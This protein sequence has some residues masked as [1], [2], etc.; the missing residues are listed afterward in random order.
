MFNTTWMDESG[1]IHYISGDPFEINWIDIKDEDG[2]LIDLAGWKIKL[3][4]FNSAGRNTILE[5]TE[6]DCDLTIP[7]TLTIRKA[8][9]DMV[10]QVGKYYFDWRM[11]KT[12]EELTTWLNNKTFFVE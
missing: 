2:S 6:T 5:L 9:A 1:N 8:A 10:M 3:R 11:G 4:V 12:E 7:G